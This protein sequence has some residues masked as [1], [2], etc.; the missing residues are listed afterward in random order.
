MAKKPQ[1]NGFLIGTAP[2]DGTH[3][4]VLRLED[5]APFEAWWCPDGDSLIDGNLINTGNWECKVG[6][7]FEQDEVAFWLPMS[8]DTTAK[9]E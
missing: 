1:E 8:S 9:S 4:L 5:Q 3:I 2:K 6:G 7:W